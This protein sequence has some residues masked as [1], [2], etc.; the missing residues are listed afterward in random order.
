MS[1]IQDPALN[2]SAM[3]SDAEG[4]KG[5]L[6]GMLTPLSEFQNRVS[7]SSMRRIDSMYD[8]IL[9]SPLM[10][11]TLLMIVAAVFGSQGLDFQE[12][13]D[14]DVEIFLPDVAPSTEL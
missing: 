7:A 11:V 3:A 9:A 4:D 12:Q 14:D 2:A 6:A 13:N 10:V 1:I 5:F 8:S